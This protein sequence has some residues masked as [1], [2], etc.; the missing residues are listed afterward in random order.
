MLRGS[1]IN[2]IHYRGFLM[3]R[4]NEP[5][6]ESSLKQPTN[7]VKD[8]QKYSVVDK[9][10]AKDSNGNQTSSY[11][12]GIQ[13]TNTNEEDFQI[14]AFQDKGT[15][16]R[17]QSIKELES[18]FGVSEVNEINTDNGKFDN[19][20]K[21]INLQSDEKKTSKINISDTSNENSSDLH[22]MTQVPHG[23]SHESHPDDFIS[24]DGHIWRAKF[25]IFAEGVLYFYENQEVA[26]C[27]EAQKERDDD[28]SDHKRHDSSFDMLSKS[29]TPRSFLNVPTNTKNITKGV[30]WEK[31]VALQNV[32]A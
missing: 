4:S 22:D 19:V 28:S 7:R 17:N 29:P 25:C 14:N 10:F 31:R 3:K 18:F 6:S 9:K 1:S 23:Q 12:T 30:F 8:V 21:S 5:L 20:S 24:Q 2:Q 13:N 27:M 16:L 26:D 32:G 15:M 11:R